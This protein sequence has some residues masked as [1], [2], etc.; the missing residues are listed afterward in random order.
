ML[1]SK[2][3]KELLQKNSRYSIDKDIESKSL[4]LLYKDSLDWQSKAIIHF[5]KKESENFE[6][7][8]KIVESNPLTEAQQKAVMANELNNL[9][10]A[11]AGSGKTSVVIARIGYL[12]KKKMAQPKDILVLAFNTDAAKEVKERIQEKLKIYIEVKTFHAYGNMI[13]NFNKT[14][15]SPCKFHDKKDKTAYKKHLRS[16]LINMLENDKNFYDEFTQYFLESFQDT[17]PLFSFKDEA[18]YNLYIRQ[19]ELKALEGSL[20]RSSEELTISNY[21]TLNSISHE[22]EPDY[23]YNTATIDRRQY[24]PDF[25]LPDYDIYIEHFG[26][27]KEGKTAPYIDSQKYNDDMEWKINL[28]EEKNTI[29]VQTFSHE[30]TDGVLL[31]TLKEKLEQYGVQFIPLPF[32]DVLSKFHDEHVIDNF[33]NLLES[34]INHFK[35]NNLTID[36]LYKRISRKQKREKSFISIFDKFLQVYEQFKQENQCIDFHD[37]ILQANNSLVNK[38]YLPQYKYIIVDEFQDISIARNNLVTLTRDFIQDSIVTV[39]GDDWQAINQFAGSDVGIIKHFEQYYGDTEIIKLDK[40]FRFDNNVGKIATRFIMKNKAQI[41]KTIITHSQVNKP[42]IFLHWYDEKDKDY[43]DN[44]IF[45]IQNKYNTKENSLMILGRNKYAF[46]DTINGIIKKYE[47]SFSPEKISFV[48]GKKVVKKGIRKMTAHRSKGLE[49]DF[50]ILTGLKE[51]IVGFPTKIEDDPILNI[52]L[53]S[54]ETIHFAEERRLF[55]VAL[56]RVKKELHLA[57]EQN[58]PSSFVMEL[59]KDFPNDIIQVNE[60]EAIDS[61]CPKCPTGIQKKQTSEYGDFITCTNYPKCDFT[62]KNIPK[63]E[64]CGD[65]YYKDKIY[66][67]CSNKNC[68]DKKEICP[69]CEGMLIEKNGKKGKF[70]GC[71]NFSTKSCTYSKSLQS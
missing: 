71:T 34:F 60:R 67:I 69:L 42:T 51:N 28:H 38:D 10:L 31:S 23:K 18:E 13:Y 59:L 5:Y 29:L 32:Q 14:R 66:Y 36:D 4:K 41:E 12:V 47:A 16:L 64:Q 50:V 35:S 27:N 57:V 22:Y 6:E 62:V 52:V 68:N 30:M 54:P 2:E 7:Y 70:M 37:M 1:Y 61:P 40:T 49:D 43:L 15:K 45:H 55:Y 9:V 46:P 25:Y 33:T 39:V 11:G 20:V 19:R 17:R 53:S 56:T 44:I 21:L 63:C 58:S 26:I 3:L 8:F 24:K 48:D 65:I